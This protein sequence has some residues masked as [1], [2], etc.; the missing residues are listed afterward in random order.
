MRGTNCWTDHYMVRAKLRE[1]VGRGVHSCPNWFKEKVDVLEPRIWEKNQAHSRWLA[2]Q[3][4]GQGRCLYCI[5]GVYCLKPREYQT[6]TFTYGPINIA[7][8][9]TSNPH[10]G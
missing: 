2:I 7:D 5:E 4:V 3:L 9:P 8:N 1:T 6:V 10:L